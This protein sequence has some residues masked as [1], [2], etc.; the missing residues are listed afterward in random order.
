MLQKKSISFESLI[1]DLIAAGWRDEF[2]LRESIVR[3]DGRGP[4]LILRIG[5]YPV[6]TIA[7]IER[8]GGRFQ[9]ELD[10]PAKDGGL[11]RIYW[12][13]VKATSADGR[14]RWNGLP[15]PQDLWKHLGRPWKESDPRLLAPMVKE[16]VTMGIAHSLALARILD[17]QL[18]GE[19]RV[20]VAV[21]MGV[22]MVAL[23]TE[24]CWR[25]VKAEKYRH[26]LVV[27]DRS[28]TAEQFFHDLAAQKDVSVARLT[29]TLSAPSSI[30]I[31]AVGYLV[32][33]GWEH[34]QEMGRDRYDLIVV[35]SVK[36]QPSM[37]RL[38]EHFS[39]SAFV[40]VQGSYEGDLPE[41][42]GHLV[43]ERPLEDVLSEAEWQPPPGKR[44]LWLGEVARILHGLPYGFRPESE[45]EKIPA[46]ILR[47]SGVPWE[48]GHPFL[49]GEEKSFAE[50]WAKKMQLQ[51]GDIVLQTIMRDSGAAFPMS[52]V[53][54]F[55]DRIVVAGRDLIIIRPT[56]P[57]IDRAELIEHLKSNLV[58]AY[59]L[60]NSSTLA[61]YARVTVRS[62]RRM[63]IFVR[64]DEEEPADALPTNR[65]AGVLAALR[66]EVLPALEALGQ[67]DRLVTDEL[68]QIAG[69]LRRV[70]KD[71]EPR[72]LDEQVLSDFPTPIALAWRRYRDARFNLYEQVLRLKDVFEATAF[73]VYNVMLA[74]H[75]RNLDPDRYVVTDKGAREAWKGGSMT[76]RMDFVD[77]LLSTAAK[78]SATDLFVSRLVGTNVVDTVKA[79]QTSFRNRVS[80][81]ATA[82]EGHQRLLIAQY[83]PIVE[84]LL[85]DLSCLAAL[86]LVRIP[87]FFY[88]HGKMERRIEIY[89]GVVPSVMEEPVKGAGLSIAAEHDHL[90]LLDGGDRML[91]LYPMYQLVESEETRHERHLCFMKS[92]RDKN[93]FGE[94][95][96]TS[97][98]L[99]LDGY[100]DFKKLQEARKTKAVP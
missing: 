92:A 96:H 8:H 28:E 52:V 98:E 48:G 54:A 41:M 70:L 29:G 85:Q 39:G 19:D 80:H 13:G 35:P 64:L 62:L 10:L 36:K 11:L 88:R 75:L 4:C 17:A 55:G 77:A 66:N 79:L 27:V 65:F 49:L 37:D 2:M 42:Y 25:L 99:H 6:A 93:L 20:R 26:A 30:E 38:L 94:D 97:L 45:E 84:S 83:A 89:R 16:H 53:P 90:V 59:L 61:G 56:D 12:D 76:A 100:D 14:V 5:L 86:R 95:A 47:S 32:A 22:G 46:A 73:F 44:T 91:D 7:P 51:A 82:G 50:S 18:G 63:P 34:L 67:A 71:I 60:H 68:G 43:Y 87:S 74:D 31:C 1:T 23:A 57:R 81:S 69:T 58:A 21:P 15:S 9:A 33:R 24:A 72:S 40:G 78:H 3:L